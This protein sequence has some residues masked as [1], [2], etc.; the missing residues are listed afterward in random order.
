MVDEED[1]IEEQEQDDSLES[2]DDCDKEF[3]SDDLADFN[4]NLIC[5]DCLQIR[6]DAGEEEEI[7]VLA[8]DLIQHPHIFKSAAEAYG[9]MVNT[10]IQVA[11]TPSPTPS[12]MTETRERYRDWNNKSRSRRV[13][14]VFVSKASNEIFNT[15][16]KRYAWD[17]M[18]PIFAKWFGSNS[19][20]IE[21]VKEQL[22]KEGL[23]L[24]YHEMPHSL[25]NEEKEQ[26]FELKSTIEA[27]TTIV[28]NVM[29]DHRLETCGNQCFKG[30]GGDIR[31][32]NYKIP[33][34]NAKNII[35]ALI[36]TKCGR[37]DLIPDDLK[38]HSAFFKQALV[39]VEKST[40]LA[41]VI[42]SKN[43]CEYII[44]SNEMPIIPPSPVVPINPRGEDDSQEEV[45]VVG[46]IS[47]ESEDSQ[48]GEEGEE[49][50]GD[51]A[52]D[53]EEKE[54]ESGNSGGPEEKESPPEQKSRPKVNQKDIEEALKGKDELDL[55]NERDIKSGTK[56]KPKW[57]KQDKE[58][59]KAQKSGKLRIKAVV[60]KLMEC[61][62]P[63]DLNQLHGISA[64]AGSGVKE[65]GN[66]TWS[67]TD[68]PTEP[69]K[70]TARRL[71][72][73]FKLIKANR[74]FRNCEYGLKVNVDNFIRKKAGTDENKLFKK[75][76]YETGVDIVYTIDC[77]SSL[78]DVEMEAEKK[79]LLTIIE[80]T[81]GI[82]NITNT[83]FGYGSMIQTKFNFPSWDSEE[84]RYDYEYACDV[85]KIDNKMLP[86]I[87]SDGG[88]PA[89][90]G[91]VHAMNYIQKHSSPGRKKLLINLTDGVPNA[92]DKVFEMV[93]FI[94][95]NGIEI[96]T[97]LIT[98]TTGSTY[99][100]QYETIYGDKKTFTII[101]DLAD[102]KDMLLKIVGTRV[103][104][105]LNV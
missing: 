21:E 48:E 23:Y 50:T 102:L 37:E 76:Q 97:I 25:T 38:M 83:V 63:D 24:D 100:T 11:F 105:M 27:L 99:G 71:G 42:T 72:M 40:S 26:F 52:S 78:S 68:E 32:I 65:L 96:F 58:I 87:H 45:E 30:I 86:Y 66:F 1:D 34:E 101:E 73:M 17:L 41:T 47:V 20:N 36:H 14:K 90:E 104:N 59:V 64:G 54:N 15:E 79:I 53:S 9:N 93:K 84:S 43:V 89:A 29:E 16:S 95:R 55:K 51:S 77:S 4:G 85:A 12:P 8:G 49:G 91:L 81:K 31:K 2:C 35:E 69:D 46:G 60:H 103:V 56:Q 70:D 28:Y 88:T 10:K 92:P 94:K 62:M 18:K 61:D 82:K 3:P 39:M 33:K 75:K 5:E 67:K 80:A 6:K 19:R 22:H 98:G 44:K 74:T 13:T 57:D 7:E